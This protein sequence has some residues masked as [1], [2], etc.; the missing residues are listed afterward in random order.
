M[1]TPISLLRILLAEVED[2]CTCD[3]TR[4]R[5]LHCRIHAVLDED[6]E[7]EPTKAVL[8]EPIAGVMVERE[9]VE[10]LMD[11]CSLEK[12]ARYCVYLNGRIDQLHQLREQF[13]SSVLQEMHN[14]RGVVYGSNLK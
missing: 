10:A 6:T 13:Q 9:L 11:E 7:T 14:L 3:A 8:K 5:C 12:L 4:D 2:E 1:D